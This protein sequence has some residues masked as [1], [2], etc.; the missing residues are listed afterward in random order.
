MS[1]NTTSESTGLYPALGRLPSGISILTIGSGDTATGMLVSWVQQAAFEPPMITL[2]VKKGRPV[3]DR[4]DAGEPF[5]LNV[6]G[7][8]DKQFLKHFGKGFE[9]GEPAF[10]GIELAETA[11]GVPALAG[12]IAHLEC[13][14]EGGVD[15]ADHRVLVAHVTGGTLLSET[16]PM[17]HLRKRG[18][19]Y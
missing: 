12:A 18:D 2:T 14:A 9:P 16:K 6:V 13:R 5:V 10:E 15:A 3:S 4:L 17:V 1:A 8:G 19:H 7:E 11:I